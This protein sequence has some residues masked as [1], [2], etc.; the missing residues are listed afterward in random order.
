[1]SADVATVL[2]SLA[3]T[4]ELG[5]PDLDRLAAL[6]R[7]VE[8][9]AG[10]TV[11]R[12]GDRDDFLYLVVEGRVALEISVPPR[13]RA[14]ILTV[15][16]GEVFGWSSVYYQQPKTAGATAVTPTR[17]LALDAA[18]LREL[19]EADCRFGYWLACRLLHVVS[20]RL[21]ATRLQLLDVFR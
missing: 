20:E 3:F 8:W 6:A 21:Q 5:P 14:R 17:A 10:R 15:G 11:F 9:Q 13:G 4:R 1:V 18:R 2:R 12:E 7:P 16:P 19:S